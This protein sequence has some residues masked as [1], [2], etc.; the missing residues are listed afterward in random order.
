[1][2]IAYIV[3]KGVP[4]GGGIEKY[5]EEVGSRL[6]S[7]GH[8]IIVY[9]MK[10]Y[11]TSDGIYRGMKI[12][13]VPTIRARS[14]EK[15]IATFTATLYQCSERKIDI[16]HFH[17]FGTSIFSFLPK[18][19]GRKIVSQGHGLE[20]KRA[21]WG[22]FTKL[23]LKISE[24]TSIKF[25]DN[26]TVVSRVQQKYLKERYG[27]DSLYI[28][29]GVN[30]P[31]IESAQLIKKYGLEGRDYIFFAA[32]LVRE[33]GVHYLIEAYNRL[34]PA[35][36]L[37]ITGDAQHEEEYKSELKK[38]AG[39]NKN[40]IFTGFATGKLLDE[41]FSN[42]YIFVLPS[43]L[44]GLSTALLE[45]MSYGNCC[46]VSDIPENLEAL[47]GLGR[48]FISKDVDSL[49]KNID[50]LISNPKLVDSIRPEAQRHVLENYSWDTIADKFE[51]LYREL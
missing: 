28:P 30:P 11:G 29:T 48:T 39:D 51:K 27:I 26:I 35:L 6:A 2:K 19:L 3:L 18:L 47:N 17:A 22:P 13:T 34:N 49:T 45:A 50:Y 31:R 40:I 36:K 8:K 33:K 14:L 41:L 32:R 23:L 37:V 10:H 16:V 43:E 20:W 9:T 25:S 15:L 7:R 12:K 21:K 24:H 4:T 42:C 44:E 38:L 46:L 1:M 5:T